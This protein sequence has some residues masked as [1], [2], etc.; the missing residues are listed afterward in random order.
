MA[1]EPVRYCEFS[2]TDYSGLLYCIFECIELA[3]SKILC[4]IC[5]FGRI[6]IGISGNVIKQPRVTRGRQGLGV[7]A[8]SWWPTVMK[9]GGSSRCVLLEVRQHGVAVQ[10]QDPSDS[11]LGGVKLSCDC[12]RTN[13]P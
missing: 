12:R 8:D 7:A 10:A 9:F 6:S 2:S 13:T 5:V 3:D 4:F 1:H 11:V